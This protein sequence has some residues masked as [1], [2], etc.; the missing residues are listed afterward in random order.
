MNRTY[1]VI[2]LTLA[3]LGAV[4]ADDSVVSVS[5]NPVPVGG[6]GIVSVKAENDDQVA[7]QV[8]PT[9]T[10]LDTNGSK[11]Y[12]NGPPGKKYTVIVTVFN[13]NKKKFTQDQIDVAI[14]GDGA[15]DPVVPVE[16]DAELKKLIGSLQDAYKL[17]PTAEKEL[18][19]ELSQL[20]SR[21]SKVTLKNAKTWGELFKLMSADA[22]CLKVSGKLMKTQEVVQSYLSGFLPKSDGSI[23]EAG[24]ARARVAFTNVSIAL[25]KVK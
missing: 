11:L 19:A 9:P 24:R 12:L 17:D 21:A 8:F 22:E 2:I 23:D 6:F 18:I 7:F 10:M 14:A 15:I 13:F 5:K 4:R 25:E 20:Y 16:P 1:S 3:L